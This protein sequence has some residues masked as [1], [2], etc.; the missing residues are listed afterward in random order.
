MSLLFSLQ[1][2]SITRFVFRAKPDGM[3]FF[4]LVGHDWCIIKLGIQGII[5]GFDV[6]ISYFM[7]DYAPRMSIQAANLEEGA[8][9]TQSGCC[10]VVGPIGPAC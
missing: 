6:D 3:S 7:G 10:G 9:R 5:R 1:F 4:R 2:C 8:L